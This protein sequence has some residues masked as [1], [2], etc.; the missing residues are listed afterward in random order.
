MFLVEMFAL[1]LNYY[2]QNPE[3]AS[4]VVYSFTALPLELIQY[5]YDLGDCDCSSITP[6]PLLSDIHTCYPGSN[7]SRVALCFMTCI[8]NFLLFAF[9]I[10]SLSH[11]TLYSDMEGC[12]DFL[13]WE[14][15]CEVV[16]ASE[17][18]KIKSIMKWC[19]TIYHL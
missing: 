4:N 19:R 3:S 9:L 18:L 14:T 12:N 1:T 6:L 16:Y 2:S 13:V 5:N 10:V 15:L 7:G 17:V 8:K 11:T